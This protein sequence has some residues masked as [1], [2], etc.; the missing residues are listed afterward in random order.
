MIATKLCPVCSASVFAPLF[1]WI[2]WT[3]AEWV[4]FY[5]PG[6]TPFCPNCARLLIVG[7][8]L[9]LRVP[10]AA[11]IADAHVTLDEIETMQEIIVSSNGF[12][13]VLQ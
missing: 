12:G 3:E 5:T 7:D 11:E 2:D 8:D 9:E 6:R 13:R 1:A 10:S 4:R